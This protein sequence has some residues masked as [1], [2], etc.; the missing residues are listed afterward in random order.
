ME[1]PYLVEYIF[2]VFNDGSNNPDIVS[3]NIKNRPQL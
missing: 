2:V 3:L 1:L